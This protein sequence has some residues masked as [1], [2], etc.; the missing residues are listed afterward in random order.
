MDMKKILLLVGA[1]VIAA[2]T[3]VMAK[4]MF[5]GAAA[6]KA[7]AAEVAGPE[8]LVATRALAVG[9]IIDAEALRYQPWPKGL[10]QEAYFM[11]GEAG[12]SPQDLLGTVVRTE[13]TAGQPLTQGALIKPGERG[14]LAAALGPGMRAV[15]VPVNIT[16]S[17]AGFVFP[18]DRVDIVLTQSVSGTGEGPP[19]KASET[20]L[21]NLRVLATNQNMKSVDKEGKPVVTKISTVTLEATPKIAEKIA[22][23]QTLGKLSLTLRALADTPEELDQA[24]ASGEINVPDGVDPAKERKM[25]ASLAAKPMDGG[26]TVTVGGDVSRYQ[27]TTVPVSAKKDPKDGTYKGPLVAIARGESVQVVPVG[28]IK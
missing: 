7:E 27:R 12:L 20:I 23:A 9:T 24:I 3:A 13:I 22:V 10:V 25:L 19:L 28:A 16:S 17:V 6:P 14:F 15:T 4:N 8:V 2:V 26:T 5:T 1:L 18:G 11:K 21:R